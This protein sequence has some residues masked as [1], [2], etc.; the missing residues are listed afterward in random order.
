M[1]WPLDWPPTYLQ[2]FLVVSLPI[3][4]LVYALLGSIKLS[5]A[6]QLELDEGR[7]GKLVSGFGMM[8]GPIILACGFLSDEFGRMGIWLFGSTATAVAIFLLATART[9]RAALLG[10]CLLGAGWSATVNVGNVLMRVAVTDPGRLLAA[11][12][13]YDFIFGFGAFMAPI[14]MAFLL[15]RLGYRPG[16]IAIAAVAVV[17]VFMGAAAEMNPGSA[18]AAAAA[19]ADPDAPSA[20]SLLVGNKYFWVISLAFLFYVPLESSTAGW[21]TTFIASQRTSGKDGSP[22]RLASVGL[23]LFW[24][25]FMGSRLVVALVGEQNLKKH[26]GE[27]PQYTMLL[28]LAVACLGIMAGLVF[29]RG[30]GV[31]FAL[32]VLSG[33]VFGPVFPAMMTML[34]AS[35]PGEAAGRAVGF[36]FFFGSI[37]WTVFPM[38]IGGI[39]KRSSIQRGFMVAVVSSAVFLALVLVR[40]AMI[41]P[42]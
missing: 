12:N 21:A 6:E 31:A 23:S 24:L 39:A 13:F 33:L 8:V 10:V 41:A 25:C 40:G 30:R 11:V 38:M 14:V 17:S 16:M 19:V 37:G 18:E 22:D 1:Q 42:K 4:G 27:H 15:R 9:F 5:L 26:L 35:V 3:M 20:F 28:G 2:L 34:L 36:F 7:V 32:V 29:L